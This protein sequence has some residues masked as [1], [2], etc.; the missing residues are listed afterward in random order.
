MTKETR[1]PNDETSRKAHAPLRAS[2]LVIPSSFV[3]RHSSLGRRT[4]P[5]SLFFGP[6]GITPTPRVLRPIEESLL[7]GTGHQ[8]VF[9]CGR[10]ATALFVAMKA[11]A[12]TRGKA[13]G[14][15]ILPAMSCT[16]PANAALLVGLRP[17][18]A[19]VDP[20]SGMATLATIRKRYTKSTCAVVFINLFGQTA[21]LT[22]LASWC[23][24]KSI[25]LIEDNAQALGAKLPGGKPVGSTGAF[26]VYSFNGK[27]ILES[28]GG[29]L[30]CDAQVWDAVATCAADCLQFA[31]RR[32]DSCDEQAEA[33]RNLYQ[34]MAGLF[35][36]RAPHASFSVYKPLI[37]Q[38]LPILIAP[39]QAP[40]ALAA[41][42]TSLRQRLADRLEKA[43]LYDRALNHT[44]CQRAD[45]WKTSGVCWRFSFFAPERTCLPSLT[46]RIRSHGCLVS[47]LYMP[48]SKLLN[49]RDR[50]PVAESL[51]HRVL[52]LCVDHTVTRDE[53]KKCGELVRSLIYPRPKRS[54][55]RPGQ[56][57]APQAERAHSVQEQ[58]GQGR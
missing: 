38:L 42:W 11:A 39:M 28:G 49:E 6:N 35:R 24:E 15:V 8:R 34:L 58:V 10:G 7:D 18:F 29:A 52:N 22:E 4:S 14:E 16:S 12:L 25:T 47:N 23:A 43:M 51:G 54:D 26:A 56:L 5:R 31:P 50:C 30:T 37:R 21:D 57:R 44:P 53:V 33:Y 17:R 48:A 13:S 3:I 55:R 36:L 20:R 1:N 46:R 9:W 45:G 41:E 27:K 32:S 19:D 2:S 40:A